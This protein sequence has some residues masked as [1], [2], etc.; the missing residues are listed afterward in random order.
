MFE[1]LFSKK[2]K[3]KKT[4]FIPNLVLEAF[5]SDRPDGTCQ[6]D[7]TG[8]AVIRISATKKDGKIWLD[9][10]VAAHEIQHLCAE[11]DPEFGQ[12]DENIVG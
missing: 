12:P 11:M 1:W 5:S 8:A 10:D 2:E 7:P 9:K 4:V 6:A 3:V